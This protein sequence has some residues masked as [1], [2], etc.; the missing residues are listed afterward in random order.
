MQVAFFISANWSLLSFSSSRLLVSSS[1]DVLNPSLLP[2][3]ICNSHSLNVS[4]LFLLLLLPFDSCFDISAS[5]RLTFTQLL[6]KSV[7]W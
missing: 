3:V 4:S 1:P 5:T 2:F 6:T 7:P